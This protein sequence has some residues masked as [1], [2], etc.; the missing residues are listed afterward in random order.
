MVIYFC[1]SSIFSYGCNPF[2]G[3]ITASLSSSAK[4]KSKKLKTYHFTKLLPFLKALTAGYVEN[5][6]SSIIP[7]V[8]IHFYFLLDEYIV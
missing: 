3:V 5:N 4:G 8:P 7:Q 1:F 6:P 2:H